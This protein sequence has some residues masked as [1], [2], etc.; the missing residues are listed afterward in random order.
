MDIVKTPR[1]GSGCGL[2]AHH[3]GCVGMQSQACRKGQMNPNTNTWPIYFSGG[4]AVLTYF[5]TF[6][7]SFCLTPF[8]DLFLRQCEFGLLGGKLWPRCDRT[9]GSIMVSY[10]ANLDK[11]SISRRGAPTLGLDCSSRASLGSLK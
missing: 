11:I 1:V 7:S 6:P 9:T 5:V 3:N 8:A 10:T 2:S 4:K